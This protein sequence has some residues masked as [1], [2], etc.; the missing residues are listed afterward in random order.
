[1][2]NLDTV[3]A[4]LF[5]TSMYCD[6]QALVSVSKIVWILFKFQHCNFVVSIIAGMHG[7]RRLTVSK[8]F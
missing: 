7:Q 8:E 3:S 6:F 1:M 2:N 5:A 4:D